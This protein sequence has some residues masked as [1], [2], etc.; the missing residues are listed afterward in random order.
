MFF[1]EL[2]EQHCVHLVIANAV[3]LSFLVMH[4][5][6]GIHLFHVLSDKA[7]LWDALGVKLLF[8]AEGHWFE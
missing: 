4:H 5:K 2:V 6:V 8:L 1:K 7:E 3:R